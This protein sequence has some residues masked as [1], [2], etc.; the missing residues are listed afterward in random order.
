MSNG[1][2]KI[3]IILNLVLNMV[4]LKSKEHTKIHEMQRI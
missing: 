3:Y 2:V 4:N 1:N